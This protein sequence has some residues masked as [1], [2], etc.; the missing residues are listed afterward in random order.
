MNKYPTLYVIQKWISGGRGLEPRLKTPVPPCFP[1]FI[2]HLSLTLGWSG[3]T[4]INVPLLCFKPRI[5][6]GHW[7]IEQLKPSD[8]CYVLES[9]L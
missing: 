8:D 7:I 3:L 6:K 1:F 5:L 4:P 9:S 2:S